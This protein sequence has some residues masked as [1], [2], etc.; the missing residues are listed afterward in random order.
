MLDDYRR[1]YVDHAQT[2]MASNNLGNAYESAG[3]FDDAISLFKQL[4]A[5]RERLLGPDDPA[6]LTAR[7]NLAYVYQS[8]GRLDDAI[9]LIWVDGGRPFPS[10]WFRQPDDARHAEKCGRSLSAGG[11]LG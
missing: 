5:D 10:L 11:G 4:L 3:R 7:N 9:T 8:V 1:D 2:L 6:T